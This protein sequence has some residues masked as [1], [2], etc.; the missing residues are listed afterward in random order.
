MKHSEQESLVGCVPPDAKAAILVPELPAS[1]LALI[2]LQVVDQEV[3]LYNSEFVVPTLLPPNAKAAVFEAPAPVTPSLLP[4][5]RLP[6]PY[7]AV[8]LYASVAAVIPAIFPPNA[9]AD[10]LVPAP[11]S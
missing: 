11:P 5:I 1:L 4:L 7:Q 9:N 2:I 3:P 6:P 8:P 10:V